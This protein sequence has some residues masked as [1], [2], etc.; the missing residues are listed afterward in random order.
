MATASYS[1]G[2]I[3]LISTVAVAQDGGADSAPFPYDHP[4]RSKLRG[5]VGYDVHFLSLRTVC[6]METGERRTVEDVPQGVRMTAAVSVAGA[7]ALAGVVWTSRSRTR[8]SMTA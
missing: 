4:C 2:A 5:A 1:L 6:V 3:G 8:V 7:A